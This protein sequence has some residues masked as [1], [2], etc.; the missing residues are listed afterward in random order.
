MQLESLREKYIIGT[1]RKSYATTYTDKSKICDVG[2][3]TERAARVICEGIAGS[4][5]FTDINGDFEPESEIASAD[6]RAEAE[7]EDN[8]Q[9]DLDKE[10]GRGKRR[11]TTNKYYSSVAFWQ[12]NDKDDWKDDSLMNQ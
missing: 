6:S 12:H 5:A 11:R 7:I 1:V 2:K 8:Q 9:L 10:E 3:Y 4:I